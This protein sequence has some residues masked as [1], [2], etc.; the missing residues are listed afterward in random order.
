MLH[1]LVPETRLTGRLRDGILRPARA[2]GG[3]YEPGSGVH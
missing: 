2:Q 1:T 3:T